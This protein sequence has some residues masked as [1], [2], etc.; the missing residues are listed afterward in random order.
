MVATV[1]QFFAF[2]TFL[3]TTY[4]SARAAFFHFT[5]MPAAPLPADTLVLAGAAIFMTNVLL[6]EPLNIPLP[7]TTT[8]A[9][10]PILTLF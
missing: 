1:V 4:L 6:A 7:V 9:E 2:P 8:F 3:S 5:V 10:L